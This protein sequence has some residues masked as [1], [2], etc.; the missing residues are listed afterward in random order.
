MAEF[1]K[2]CPH[3]NANLRVQD[4]W[5]GRNVRCPKCRK[6]FTISDFPKQEPDHNEQFEVETAASECGNVQE[7]RTFTFWFVSLCMTFLAVLFIAGLPIFFILSILHGGSPLWAVL[8]FWAFLLIFI[9]IIYFRHKRKKKDIH[10]KDSLIRSYIVAVVFCI[11]GYNID[12]YPKESTSVVKN[13]PSP[14]RE[15]VRQMQPEPA[16]QPAPIVKKEME[17]TNSTKAKSQGLQF[18]GISVNESQYNIKKHLLNRGF[19]EYS[20]VFTGKFWILSGNSLAR[21]SFGL[22]K[23]IVRFEMDPRTDMEISFK[24]I[25]LKVK[26]ALGDDVPEIRELCRMYYRLIEQNNQCLKQYFN[27]L[28][29]RYGAAKMLDDNHGIIKLNDGLI[30]LVQRPYILQDDYRFDNCCYVIFYSSSAARI[31]L[32]EME[33]ARNENN[34]RYNDI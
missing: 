13:V 11:C 7:K 18:L 25:G 1:I 2:M 12:F 3:C 14:R 16:A 9:L 22:G 26:T 34:R 32:K 15:P 27:A 4:E 5:I 23:I 6:Q 20:G 33:E 30:E 29:E 24:L 28:Q 17:A 19:S 21:V 10:A 31:R 8:T